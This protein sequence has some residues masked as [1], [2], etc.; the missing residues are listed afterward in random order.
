[1]VKSIV[2]IGNGGHAKVIKDMI[3]RNSE[4]ELVG[5]LDGNIEEYHVREDIFY[6]HTDQILKYIEYQFIIAIGN[7]YV[8]K[9]IVDQ[10][11]LSDDRFAA[12]I[13]PSAIVSDSVII[14]PGTV[15]M[16]NVV[17]NSSSTI[18]AHSII[19]TGA[20]IEHDNRIDDYVHISP[21]A[22][23][24]G[25]VSVG[26][27]THI[28]SNATV[29][30]NQTIGSKSIVGAGAVVVQNLSDKVVAVGNPAQVIKNID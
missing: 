24:A 22:T 19:N 9:R 28:G 4:L 30:P 23:L 16:P 25:T 2:M 1:M 27:L 14:G 5:I 3:Q 6:D 7:N 8:R 12:V 18:G 15:I 10:F 21:A 29:I 11:N 20:I 13:D 17:I 26:S